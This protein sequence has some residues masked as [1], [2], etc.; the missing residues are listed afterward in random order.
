MTPALFMPCFF[1][2]FFLL[3]FFYSFLCRNINMQYIIL[4]LRSRTF[5]ILILF[6]PAFN[7][8][9]DNTN[10]VYLWPCQHYVEIILRSLSLKGL[11][12]WDF[13]RCVEQNCI[14]EFQKKV[15]EQKLQPNQ[16]ATLPVSA[17]Y[18][19]VPLWIMTETCSFDIEYSIAWS[20]NIC[21]KHKMLKNWYLNQYCI[22][23]SFCLLSGIILSRSEKYL[24]ISVLQQ[25][26]E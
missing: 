17:L 10:C 7:S 18:Q 22:L 26:V 20:I 3:F 15:F 21:N 8:L 5:N 11:K 16:L 19:F 1:F 25:D 9:N 14:T 2:F 12:C 24:L 4:K 23:N 6:L 13:K